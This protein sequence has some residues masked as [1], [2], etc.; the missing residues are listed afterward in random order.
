MHASLCDINHINTRPGNSTVILYCKIILFSS[1]TSYMKIAFLYYLILHLCA[2]NLFWVS[3]HIT[4]FCPA[5]T[6]ELKPKKKP[7]GDQSNC[8]NKT[9]C[10]CPQCTEPATPSHGTVVSMVC[11][12][13]LLPNHTGDLQES[14]LWLSHST[15][16][17]SQTHSR[18]T[19]RQR[20]ELTQD[21]CGFKVKST[22]LHWLNVP[23]PKPQQTTI[24]TKMLKCAP[25]AY[26]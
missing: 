9:L 3:F 15:R 22:V 6:H 7:F 11:K 5:H 20:V 24:L 17:L 26:F 19:E 23:Q 14:K 21:V 8:S 1:Y 2:K 12:P 25:S 13:L 4:S 18:E 16:A 10:L